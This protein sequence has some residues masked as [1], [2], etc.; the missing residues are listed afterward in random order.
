MDTC[1]LFPL[2]RQGSNLEV[3]KS[4]YCHAGFSDCERYKLS[5]SGKEVPLA[6]LPNGD[7]LPG[8]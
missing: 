8:V 3:W 5:Q 2:F 7:Q 6:L 1:P 4:I